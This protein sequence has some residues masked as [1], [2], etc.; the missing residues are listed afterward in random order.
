MQ[1]ENSRIYKWLNDF[2]R[3]VENTLDREMVDRGSTN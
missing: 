2:S 1:D 3:L